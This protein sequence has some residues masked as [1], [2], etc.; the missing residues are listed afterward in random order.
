[1]EK[2]SW[3]HWYPF[4]LNGNPRSNAATSLSSHS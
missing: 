1:M 4:S 3:L 2:I